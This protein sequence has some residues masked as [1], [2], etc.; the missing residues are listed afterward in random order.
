MVRGWKRT[1]L[2][3]LGGGIG[4]Y[5]T[6]KHYPDPLVTAIGAFI[7]VLTVAIIIHFTKKPP[8]IEFSD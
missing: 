4:A 2:L 7:G 3:A 5:L 6:A 8:L 1:L